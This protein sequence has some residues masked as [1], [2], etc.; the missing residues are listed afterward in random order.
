MHFDHK[1]IDRIHTLLFES[2]K[3]LSEQ[4]DYLI[5]TGIVEAPANEALHKHSKQL[6]EHLRLTVYQA[7]KAIDTLNAD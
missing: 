5:H 3:M 4:N 2:C 7:L 1:N 6:N